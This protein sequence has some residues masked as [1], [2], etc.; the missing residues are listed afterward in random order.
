MERIV[1]IDEMDGWMIGDDAQYSRS[2]IHR[3]IWYSVGVD[4]EDINSLD[5][6]PEGPTRLLQWLHKHGNNNP[7]YVWYC[8]GRDKWDVLLNIM[9]AAD[10]MGN[11]VL[12]LMKGTSLSTGTEYISE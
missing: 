3:C 4:N 7:G 8:I 9:K 2:Q 6:F 1:Q 11:Q 5:A 10:S 12:S